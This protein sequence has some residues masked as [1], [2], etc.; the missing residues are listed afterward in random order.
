MARARR[1]A[2]KPMREGECRTTKTGMEYCKLGGTVEFTRKVGRRAA[3]RRR[4]TTRRRTS[5]RRRKPARRR[6]R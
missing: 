1:K 3:P 2:S 5:T 4:K 6:A